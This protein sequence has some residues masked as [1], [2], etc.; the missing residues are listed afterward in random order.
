MV[1]FGLGLTP[2]VRPN[3][4]HTNLKIISG[5]DPVKEVVIYNAQGRAVNFFVNNSGTDD[6]NINLS[7]LAKGVYFLKIKTEPK[8]FEAR[9]L[10]E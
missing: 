4:V 2:V 8:I 9:I 3:P 1:K 6:M 10:K 7:T 5:T